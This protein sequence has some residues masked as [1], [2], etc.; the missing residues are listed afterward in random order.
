[1]ISVLGWRWEQGKDC[2]GRHLSVSVGLA[3]RDSTFTEAV[4]YRRFGSRWD[5]VTEGVTYSALV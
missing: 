1:M 5:T 3:W 2:K 4:K